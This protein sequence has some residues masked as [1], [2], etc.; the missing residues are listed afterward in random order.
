MG[1]SERVADREKLLKSLNDIA[2]QLT[3]PSIAHEDKQIPGWLQD[4]LKEQAQR[5]GLSQ[6]NLGKPSSRQDAVLLAK[7]FKSIIDMVEKEYEKNSHF[8]QNHTIKKTFPSQKINEN[9]LTQTESYLLI[10]IAHNIAIKEMTRQVSV[11]CIERGM[12]LKTIFDS[13]VRM[14]DLVFVDSVAQRKLLAS[15]FATV[16]EKQVFYQ[17]EQIAKKDAV[18]AEKDRFIEDINME[19]QINKQK[20]LALQMTNKKLTAIAHRHQVEQ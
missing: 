1:K 15:K 20:I 9:Q 2:D 10:Q 6:A 5:M 13:Y 12:L 8:Y 11:Q 3:K 16:F 14:V 4:N 7:W 18:L 17:K 19:N